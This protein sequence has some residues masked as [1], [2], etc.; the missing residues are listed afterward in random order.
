MLEQVRSLVITK[1][2]L[3][4]HLDPD[5]YTK[6]DFYYVGSICMQFK[7]VATSQQTKMSPANAH[8][9]GMSN[10]QCI[11]NARLA[12]FFLRSGTKM[13]RCMNVVSAFECIKTVEN[14]V[15][16]VYYRHV[17]PKNSMYNCTLYKHIQRKIFV[18]RIFIEITL[19]H[20][21][22]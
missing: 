21:K 13:S 19:S 5:T 3:T 11:V 15:E 18:C 22:G 7:K 20:S 16:K 1:C 8:L 9:R 6:Y 10:V 14:Y 12:E 4:S 2:D 17:C